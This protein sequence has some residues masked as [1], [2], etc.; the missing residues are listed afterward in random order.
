VLVFALDDMRNRDGAEAFC[1]DALPDYELLEMVLYG[2]RAGS[3]GLLV[4]H[5]VN[6]RIARHG[7]YRGV[8]GP[9]CEIG[10]KAATEA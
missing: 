1:A 5:H 10:K 9:P 3:V 8:T 6:P 7:R 2:V 4:A